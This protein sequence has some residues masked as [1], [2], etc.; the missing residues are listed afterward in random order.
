MC[1]RD[2]SWPPLL[3]YGG[4]ASVDYYDSPITSIVC[5]GGICIYSYEAGNQSETVGQHGA[6]TLSFLAARRISSFQTNIGNR[7]EIFKFVGAAESR[8]YVYEPGITEDY[9]ELDYGLI[10]ANHTATID[11]GLVSHTDAVT[12]TDRG[13]ILDGYRTRFGFKKTIGEVQAKATNACERQVRTFLPS[14][15]QD[16]N[17][18]LYTSPSPRDRG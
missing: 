9:N 5:S 3:R 12:I 16:E 10:T 1:I 11:N 18:L 2:R 8:G 17:C 15:R 4:S 7:T 6:S 14:K 13:N